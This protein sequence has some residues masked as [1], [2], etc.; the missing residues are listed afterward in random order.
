[1]TKYYNNSDTTFGIIVTNTEFSGISRNEAQNFEDK[2][3][4][5][6]CHYKELEITL[7][8]IYKIRNEILNNQNMMITSV[9]DNIKNLQFN[10]NNMIIT[11]ESVEKHTL[12]FNGK[13]FF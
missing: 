10:F 2:N 8:K 7:E 5:F 4:I 9:S 13:N 1:M 12:N 6:L 3:R 11:C